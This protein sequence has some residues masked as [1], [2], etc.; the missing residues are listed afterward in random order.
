[1]RER[2]HDDHGPLYAVMKA[3]VDDDDDHEVKY[4]DDDLSK[5]Y[6]GDGH[7]AN[8]GDDDSSRKYDDDAP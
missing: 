1:M 4:G 3:H 7:E 6:V 2:T 5:M 8:D